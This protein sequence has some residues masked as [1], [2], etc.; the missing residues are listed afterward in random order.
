VLFILYGSLY[1]FQFVAR[2]S[3]DGAVTYLLS[4]WRDWDH[5][6]DLLSN[7]GLYMPLGCLVALVLPGGTHGVVRLLAGTACGI[8]LSVAIEITQVY[9][10]ERVASLGDVYANGIGSA[11]GAIFGAIIGIGTRWPLIGE[12]AA[13]PRS[14]LLLVLWTGYRL[15]PYVPTADA[16]A[17]WHNLHPLLLHPSLPPGEWA[18]FTIVWLLIASL[19]DRLYGFRRWSLLFPLLAAAEFAARIVITGAGLKLADIV[20]AAAA[21][22]IWP[23]LRRLPECFSILSVALATLVVAIRLAPFDLQPSVRGFGWVPFNSIMHGS[24]GVAIQALLEKSY[25]YGGVI[26]MSTRAGLSLG[27]ATALTALLLLACGYAETWLPG[28][29][30]EVTDAVIALVLGGAFHLF[31]EDSTGRSGHRS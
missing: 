25:L 12:L 1:P 16:H 14:S 23:V 10:P 4:T 6:G 20:G 17:W 7:I 28:R 22:V 21:V 24:I 8:L 30:A 26:W 15:Y 3:A 31:P 11:L 18:R 9:N 27:S 19:L 13:H 2:A 29:S 5:P